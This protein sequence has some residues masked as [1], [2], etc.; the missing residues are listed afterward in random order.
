M[1]ID[2]VGSFFIG[3]LITV[4]IWAAYIATPHLVTY[5]DDTCVLLRSEIINCFAT[6]EA[7]GE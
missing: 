5:G 2:T 1:N 3:V 7:Q 6:E 4:F